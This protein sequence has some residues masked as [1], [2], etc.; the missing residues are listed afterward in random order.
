MAYDQR[1]LELHNILCD[2]LGSSHCYFQP[3]E[4]ILLEYPCIIYERSMGEP[5]FADNN[6]YTNMW[7][8]AVIVIDRD[9]DTDI[10]GKVAELPLCSADRFYQ[11]DNLNHYSFTLFY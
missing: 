7:Q 10:P 9:P 2:I 6:L 5:R 8:Y 4:D 11:A 1:R 3:P